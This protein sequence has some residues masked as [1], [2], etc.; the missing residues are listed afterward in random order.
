MRDYYT[1]FLKTKISVN[2]PPSEVSKVSKGQNLDTKQAFDTFDTSLPNV[3]QKIN[4]VA[5]KKSPKTE[6]ISLT[7]RLNA[8]VAAGASSDVGTDDFQVFGADCLTGSEKQ[9]LVTNKSAV[10][11]ILQQAA[12]KKYLSL[13]DLQM[14][15]YEVKERAATVSDGETLEPT[16]EIVSTITGEWFADLLAEMSEPV[17]TFKN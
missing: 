16:F 3:N 10:L 9:F 6:R 14:F 15:T 7:I 4:F 5:G 12:L 1:D 2:T 17:S 11:C 8:M 13:D